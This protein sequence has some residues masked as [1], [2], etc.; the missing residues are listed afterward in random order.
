MN[1]E[2]EWLTLYNVLATSVGSLV[3]LCQTTSSILKDGGSGP[4]LRDY[5][6][7]VLM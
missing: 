5:C 7:C 6:H 4:V 3:L 1:D 2:L